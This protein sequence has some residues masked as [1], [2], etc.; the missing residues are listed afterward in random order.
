LDAV[1]GVIEKGHAGALQRGTERLDRPVKGRFVQVELR[2]APHQREAQAGEGVGDELRV[3]GRIGEPRHRVI[4]AVANHERH[5]PLRLRRGRA[6]HE[7]QHECDRTDT[8]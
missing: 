4:L 5:P 3:I 8:V 1:A 6:R 7:E 2:L